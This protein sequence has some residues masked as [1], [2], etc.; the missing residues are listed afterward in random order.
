[1]QWIGVRLA[2]LLC[3]LAAV[4]HA[5][6][7][8]R[9]LAAAEDVPLMD[10][11]A[12]TQE[13]VVFESPMGTLIRS[14]AEGESD[15]ESIRRFYSEA[16]PALGWRS[17]GPDRYVREDQRLSLT[18]R[19]LAGAQPDRLAVDFMLVGGGPASDTAAPIPAVSGVTAP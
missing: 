18:I 2:I 10:G 16:L 3:S 1:M 9:F 14:H 4:A 12:E 6:A 13:P 7:P 5:Q 17:D 11:L 8:G 19:L 15:A